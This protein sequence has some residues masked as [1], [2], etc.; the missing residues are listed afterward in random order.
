MTIENLEV[1]IIGS[2]QNAAKSIDDL[3]NALER[4]KKALSIGNMARFGNDLGDFNKALEKLKPEVIERYER[5]ATALERIA[6][7]RNIKAPKIPSGGTGGGGADTDTDERIKKTDTMLKKF[8]R[9][10][11]RIA[12]YRAIRAMVSSVTNAMKEGLEY[13]YKYSST[14]GG[15]IGRVAQALDKLSSASFKMKNQLGSAFAE[16]LTA[17]TPTL[18]QIVN[19]VTRAADAIAQFFAVINGGS[20]YMKAIDYTKK[21]SNA[22]ASGAAA[23]KEWKNQ[24]MGF[25]ELNVLTA[26]SAAGG[27]GSSALNIDPSSL[28]EVAEVSERIAN[29][30][31]TIKDKWHEIKDVASAVAVFLTGFNMLKIFAPLIGLDKVIGLAA[32]ILGIYE[33]V[34]GLKQIKDEGYASADSIK[35]LLAGIGLIGITIGLITGSWI[36]LLV[37]AF[38]LM[39]ASIASVWDKVAL[40]VQGIVNGIID[41]IN[42]LIEK[43]NAINQFL[44]GTPDYISKLNRVTFHGGT[45]GK[46]ADGGYPATGELFIAREAGPEMVGTMGGHTAVANN[47]QI[48]EGIKAGVYE[49]VRAAMPQNQS[50]GEYRFYLDGKE[51]TA[52][53]TQLQR[54]NSR[55]MG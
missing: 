39:G 8:G 9:S 6:A 51:L 41:A 13:A 46:F 47:Q 29:I 49:A 28:Y 26:P 15:E 12:F 52:R 31:Q 37:G 10:I 19:L 18:I 44:G 35:H 32:I 20:T 3:V 30:A 14:I 16:V 54:Q 36:P 23:A 2:S 48:V 1:Q 5:L 17:L 38:A 22:T 21:W 11:A 43:F 34:K 4:F 55:A 33:I 7:Q 42:W 25:D 50:G 53:V 27:G 45:G 40:K 24:L